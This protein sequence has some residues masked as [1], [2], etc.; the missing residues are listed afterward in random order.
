MHLTLKQT[1]RGIHMHQCTH[2]HTLHTIHTK[3]MCLHQHSV[4]KRP[5]HNQLVSSGTVLKKP[6]RLTSLAQTDLNR[7]SYLSAFPILYSLLN[8]CVQMCM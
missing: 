6:R 1:H 8:G 5:A 4:K 2:T 7:C 3:K